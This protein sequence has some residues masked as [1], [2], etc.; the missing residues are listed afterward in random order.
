MPSFYVFLSS[1][2]NVAKKRWEKYGNVKKATINKSPDMSS[3]KSQPTLNCAADVLAA[4]NPPKSFSAL[5]RAETAAIAKKRKK[6]K[7][8]TAGTSGTA[9][10]SSAKGKPS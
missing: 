2:S 4:A 3:V 5:A 7:K 8:K 9:A 1:N 6:K 10:V